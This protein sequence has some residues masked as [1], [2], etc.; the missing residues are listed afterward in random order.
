MKYT[1]SEAKRMIPNNI[2]DVGLKDDDCGLR[3]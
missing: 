1:N 3:L 2:S